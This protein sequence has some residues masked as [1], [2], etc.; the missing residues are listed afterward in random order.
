[1]LQLLQTLLNRL[2]NP[3]LQR[4]CR[5]ADPVPFSLNCSGKSSTVI[6]HDAAFSSSCLR[7]AAS[8]DV[9]SHR[10]SV[11][12]VLLLDPYISFQPMSTLSGAHNTHCAQQQAHH[13]SNVSCP[14]D[15]SPCCI[16]SELTASASSCWSIICS[17]QHS[18][19]TSLYF[20]CGKGIC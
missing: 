20:G 13:T 8:L 17:R 18:S 12:I 10:K 14:T 2:T 1:M 9:T 16:S 6:R 5:H 15:Q 19:F 3:S 11:L 4:M 7:R